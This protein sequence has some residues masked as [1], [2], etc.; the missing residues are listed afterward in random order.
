ML[1]F[2]DISFGE[3]VI[4]FFAFLILFG[5]QSI[6]GL[7]QNLGRFLFYARRTKDEIQKEFFKSTEQVHHYIQTTRQ[8]VEKNTK[9]FAN[10]EK[11]RAEAKSIQQLKTKNNSI[12]QDQKDILNRKLL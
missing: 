5:P 8:E 12:I 3:L 6:P 2:L 9:Y 11:K 1:L 4:V 10:L 7:M